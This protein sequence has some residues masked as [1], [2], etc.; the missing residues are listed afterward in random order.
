MLDRRW[1][2]WWHDAGVDDGV[3]AVRW[4]ALLWCVFSFSAAV[5]VGVC[6][7]HG[8]LSCCS[9]CACAWA[10]VWACVWAC[11]CVC[12]AA[13]W[14]CCAC[15]CGCARAF[16]SVVTFWSCCKLMPA[17]VSVC[18]GLRKCQPLLMLNSRSVFADCVCL[19]TML[20]LLRH[21]ASCTTW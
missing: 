13:T 12:W 1:V 15:V 9:C 16:C 14:I 4:M 18:L 19:Q 20:R 21:D 10:R 17:C 8:V 2:S 3:G 7:S 5:T 11:A 6:C